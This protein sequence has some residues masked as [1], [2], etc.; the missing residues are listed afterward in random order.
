MVAFKNATQEKKKLNWTSFVLYILMQPYV[1]PNS[2]L[3]VLYFVD[4]LVVVIHQLDFQ[5]LHHLTFTH[6]R[7]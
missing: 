5:A 1:N 2:S 7:I 3:L 6:N 4:P